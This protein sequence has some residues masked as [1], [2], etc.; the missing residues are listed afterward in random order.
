MAINAPLV[1]KP[2]LPETVIAHQKEMA[3]L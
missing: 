1:A 2:T 3:F